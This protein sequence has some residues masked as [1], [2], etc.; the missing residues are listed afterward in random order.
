LRYPGPGWAV[1]LDA[2]ER[3]I[4][5]SRKIFGAMSVV[6]RLV[7]PQEEGRRRDMANRKPLP[8]K[9]VWFELVTRDARKAQAFYGEVLGWKIKPFQLGPQSYDMI[10]TGETLDT[11]IGGYAPPRNDRPSHW[12]SYLSV[13]DVDAA[14]RAAA[15]AG[16]KLVEP[17]AD[18]PGVGRSA[19]I[20]DPQGA[21]LCLFHNKDGD[22]PDQDAPLGTFFWNE[23]HTTDPAAALAFYEKVVG[24][25]HQ[26]MDMGPAGKYHVIGKGGVDRGGITE[27]LPPG[28]MPHWLPYVRVEDVD[29]TLARAR[30]LGAALHV[31]AEDIPGVGRFGVF[32][33][34]V[35]AALA[36]MKPMPPAK[37]RA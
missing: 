26:S 20:A 7:R 12:I 29:G 8:G 19:R 5:A 32:I 30:R 25:S 2:A 3:A 34:P 24:F 35:G 22:P 33:D 27:H 16:G 17:P 15:A 21:E 18:L 9:F 31:D 14:A 23:L 1:K 13:E 36:I 10:C 28:T 4:A 11:M 37:P 6:R